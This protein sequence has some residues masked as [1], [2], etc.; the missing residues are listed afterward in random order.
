MAALIGHAANPDMVK[1]RS[2]GSACQ[3]S[4]SI[5]AARPAVAA[6]SATTTTDSAWRVAPG[7]SA[8]SSNTPGSH[9]S[10]PRSRPQAERFRWEGRLASGGAVVVVAPASP[11]QSVASGSLAGS[12][13]NSRFDATPPALSRSSLSVRFNSSPW[14]PVR[15][16]FYVIEVPGK[17]GWPPL[18]RTLSAQC[19]RWRK[20]PLRQVSDPSLPQRREAAGGAW[21]GP[22]GGDGSDRSPP[23]IAGPCASLVGPSQQFL[24]AL[25]GSV[26]EDPNCKRIGTQ[27]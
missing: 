21:P 9:R 23:R 11:T 14:M 18:A 3:E 10:V 25:N 8:I 12:R 27:E 22:T 20:P 19:R 24:R 5:P 4:Q 16:A 6:R 2:I 13:L 26:G 7:S 15:S 1:S 17:E